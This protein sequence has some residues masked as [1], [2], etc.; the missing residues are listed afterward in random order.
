MINYPIWF[1]KNTDLKISLNINIKFEKKS[2][3]YYT[4]EHDILNLNSYFF[5]LNIFDKIR[6]I[7][8]S[9]IIAS[10]I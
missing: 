6:T 1:S 10:K 2:Y 5:F 7:Y 9:S 4:S 3:L 8:F